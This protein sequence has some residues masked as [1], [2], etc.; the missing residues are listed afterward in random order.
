MINQRRFFHELNS[1]LRD[2]LDCAKLKFDDANKNLSKQD[3]AAIFTLYAYVKNFDGTQSKATAFNLSISDINFHSKEISR[4]Y[5][6][7]I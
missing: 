5:Y 1:L 2:F 4:L 6:R 7:N 3:D